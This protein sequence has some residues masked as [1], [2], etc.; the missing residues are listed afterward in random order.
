MCSGSTCPKGSGGSSSSTGTTGATGVTVPTSTTGG[1]S[2]GA[3]I[4]PM[5]ITGKVNMGVTLPS[6]TTADAFVKDA[7]VIR[8]VKNGVAAKV[9][10]TASWVSVVL[11]VDSSSRRLAGGAA[12]I[13]L[14]VDY[15]VT[16]PSGESAAKVSN[17]QSA[18][19]G[20]ASSD[21]TAW[22]SMINTE[23]KKE[24]PNVTVTV[25]GV[26]APVT[27]TATAPTPGPIPSVLQ[28]KEVI[29][30]KDKDDNNLGLVIAAVGGGVLILLCLLLVIRKG[31]SRRQEETEPG[32][33]PKPVPDASPVAPAPEQVVEAV[34]EPVKESPPLLE[35]TEP[36]P[37]A[38]PV[39]P[40]T[41]E[42]P[43]A[44]NPEDNALP[45]LPVEESV[46]PDAAIV[47]Q[48]PAPPEVGQL[49]VPMTFV[50]DMDVT[51]HAEPQPPQ[52]DGLPCPRKCGFMC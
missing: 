10:C 24:K 15:T 44:T 22:S 21:K 38:P 34:E 52:L 43:P 1:S 16:V 13:K 25:T 33:V 7:A 5:Q 27:V 4:A 2:T 19:S 45:A 50:S 8:G 26:V 28:S 17:V 9:G 36:Q 42:P 40:E 18:L 6:G 37:V 11:S 29:A 32:I 39:E 20:S 12:S 31:C 49:T 46:K 3:T 30:A 47:V 41:A 23:L 51:Y 35:T 14:S 48:E